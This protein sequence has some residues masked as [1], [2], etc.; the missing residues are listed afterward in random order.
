MTNAIDSLESD[1]SA[2]ALLVATARSTFQSSRLSEELSSFIPLELR[3]LFLLPRTRRYCFVLRMLMRFDLE[4]SSKIL[5]LSQ[6]EVG[7]ALCESLLD[8]PRAAESIG[9]RPLLQ[10]STGS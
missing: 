2:D 6:K 10:E 1:L 8:L 7:Q 3:P 4:T 9:R 5:K